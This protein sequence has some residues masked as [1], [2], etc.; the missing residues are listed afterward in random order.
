MRIVIDGNIGSGKTTVIEKLYK[1]YPKV[2]PEPIQEW[3]EWLKKFYSDMNKN[4]LGFQLKVLKTHIDRKKYPTG[5]FERSPLSCQMVFGKILHQ[6]KLIDDLE[7]NL[8]Q[9]YFHDFGWVPNKIV[10]LRC[11]PETCLERIR[12]RNRESEDKIPLDYLTKIHNNYE[13]LYST[14]NDVIIIDAEKDENEVYNIIT[15]LLNLD[16]LSE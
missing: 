1:R 5:I 9:E 2:Y 4:A 13:E 7:F 12:N 6:D 15:H 3:K 8:C 14:R 11:S 16:C 10:Y